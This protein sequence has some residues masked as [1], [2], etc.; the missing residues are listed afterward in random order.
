[1]L[2]HSG[3]SLIPGQSRSVISMLATFERTGTITEHAVWGAKDVNNLENLVLLEWNVL[4]G[5][6]LRLFAFEYRSQTG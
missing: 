1:M 3:I 4:L 2:G 6:E 5:V